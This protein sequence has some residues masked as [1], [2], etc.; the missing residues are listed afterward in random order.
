MPDDV[1]DGELASLVKFRERMAGSFRR[2][3]DTLIETVDAM[4]CSGRP[5]A[6]PAWLTLEPELR[7][8]YGC[9]YQALETEGAVDAGGLCDALVAA[10]TGRGLPSWWAVDVTPW[11]RPEAHMSPDRSMVYT[12]GCDG[13]VATPGWPALVIAHVG[14][15]RSAQVLPVD[16]ELLS[17]SQN[18]N[19]VAAAGI[20]RVL[21]SL[22]RTGPGAGMV[23]LFLLD[24]G[25]CPIYLTQH[26]AEDAQ[27]LVRLRKDRVF[28]ARA[29]PKPPSRRGPQAKHGARFKLSDPSTHHEPDQTVE[30]IM[31]A[32]GD[33]VVV[34]ADIW[35]RMHP[36]PR[37]RRKWDSDDPVEGTIIHRVAVWTRTGHTQDWWLWWA[38]PADSFDEVIT[39]AYLHRFSIEHGFKF[40]KGLGWTNYKPITSQAAT[41]WTW[42]ILAAICHFILARDLAEDYRLPWDQPGPPTPARVHRVFRRTWNRLPRLASAPRNSRPGTGRPPGIPNRNQHTKQKVTRKGRA[43]NTGHPKGR[44]HRLAPEHETTEP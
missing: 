10:A 22:E 17:G 37:Q 44:R 25:F 43:P 16:A 21:D 8:G 23:P 27:I 41:N 42:L 14:D 34:T 5:I 24:A 31:H 28:Y 40:A 15:E 7:R 38:G 29:E 30:T 32:G 19:D 35:H 36:A 9:V 39:Q 4:T 13:Q 2:W 33:E 11:P 20:R 1:V 6:S 26:V 3:S 18:T 12:G